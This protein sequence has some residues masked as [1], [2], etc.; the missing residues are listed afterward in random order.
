MIQRFKD[1]DDTKAYG[2]IQQLPKGGYELLVMGVQV[3]N[4]SKG[5]YMKIACDISYG[6]Y[7]GFFKTD[8]DNQQ[9]EDKKWHCNYLLS[10]PNDDGS[11]QDGW[12]KRRFKTVMEAFE[13]S[14]KGYHW[15]WD[16]QTLKGKKIGGLFNIREYEKDGKVRSATNLAQLVSVKTIKDGTFKLPEDKLIN[17]R[18]S[19][20]GFVNAG[21]DSGKEF[22]PFA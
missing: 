14:N 16:E 10:I 22:N 21:T 9:T 11:E 19:A 6:E 18:P 13:D 17:K 4:N 8:Y 12:T 15:N 3:E 7:L 5:S 2:E 1:Y 20:D